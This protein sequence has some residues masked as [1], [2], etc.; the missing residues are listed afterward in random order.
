MIRFFF[1][2]VILLSANAISAQQDDPNIN[3]MVTE[4]SWR[5]EAFTFPKPFAPEVNF[6]GIADVRFTKGWSNVESDLFWSYAFAWKIEEKLTEAEL[7]HYLQLYFDGLMQLVNRDKTK[8]VPQTN[9]LFISTL[10]DDSQLGYTGKIR[11]FDAFFTSEM[12][13][14]HVNGEYDYCSELDKHVYI[15]RLSP[16]PVGDAVW[17]HINKTVMRQD[18]CNK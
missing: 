8:E 11:L 5:K 2:L 12:I 13:T 9:A 14:L 6:K 10:N 18:I 3:L 16:K 7:E 15:F 1:L 17:N 4:D